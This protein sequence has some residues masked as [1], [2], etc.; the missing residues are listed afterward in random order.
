MGQVSAPEM[1]SPEQLRRGTL[2]SFRRFRFSPIWD[3]ARNRGRRAG[4]HTQHV[5][6]LGTHRRPALSLT[7][8][9]RQLHGTSCVQPAPGAMARFSRD[10]STKYPTFTS[11]AWPVGA[12]RAQRPPV[13]KVRVKVPDRSGRTAP[14]HGFSST[15][16]ALNPRS[17]EIRQGGAQ[18]AGLGLVTGRTPVQ[19]ASGREK[20]TGS[21]SAP[22]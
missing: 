6:P 16:P 21:I 12:R 4:T 2:N 22:S 1:S 9:R 7:S 3:G 5:F 10:R 13:G 14:I 8:R 20:R 15:P 18:P 11:P 19:A 17:K